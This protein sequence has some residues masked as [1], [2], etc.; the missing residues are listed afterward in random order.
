MISKNDNK[1]QTKF[2]IVDSKK[3]LARI[4]LIYYIKSRESLY[5]SEPSPTFTDVD[6]LLR[7]LKVI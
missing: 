6:E 4:D 3:K 7:E 2:W 1:N 5:Y